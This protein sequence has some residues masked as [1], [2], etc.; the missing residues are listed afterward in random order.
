VTKFASRARLGLVLFHPAPNYHD[1]LPNKLFEYMSGGLPV[2]AS[3]FPA[4][5]EIVESNGCGLVVDPMNTGE[6]AEAIAWL[7]DHP[8]EAEAMGKRGQAA[9]RSTYNWDTQAESLLGLYE[10][11]LQ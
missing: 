8:A 7:L 1:S 4:W 3:N 10:R 2:V 6:I 11:V 9:V 5:R